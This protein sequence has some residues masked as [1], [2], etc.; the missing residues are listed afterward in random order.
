[1]PPVEPTSVWFDDLPEPIDLSRPQK[2][3]LYWTDR[4]NPPLG[5]TVNRASVDAPAERTHLNASSAI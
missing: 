1:M 2:P 5:S 3:L 4:G